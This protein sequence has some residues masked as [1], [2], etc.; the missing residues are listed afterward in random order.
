MF[1]ISDT[2]RF[3]R[4]TSGISRDKR[5]YF[6]QKY[7]DGSKQGHSLLLEFAQAAKF[8]TSWVQ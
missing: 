1:D 5:D 3:E 4:L 7:R 6:I 2:S 8:P